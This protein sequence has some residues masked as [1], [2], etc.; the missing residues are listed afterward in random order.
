[1]FRFLPNNNELIFLKKL[2]LLLQ[3]IS[4]QKQGKRVTKTTDIKCACL[5]I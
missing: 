2:T 5:L 1:M 3:K 4:K